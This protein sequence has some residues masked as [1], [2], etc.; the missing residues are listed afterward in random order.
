MQPGVKF[1]VELNQDRL[2]VQLTG[3]PAFQVFPE[4]RTVFFYKAVDAKIRFESES[5]GKVTGLVLEQGG[6]K[7]PATKI[8]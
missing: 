5:S 1:Y 6:Q 7:M 4:S 2:M 8:K 3:Q